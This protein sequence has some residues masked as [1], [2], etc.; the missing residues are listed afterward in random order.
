MGVF[1][2]AV[3]SLNLSLLASLGLVATE[4]LIIADLLSLALFSSDKLFELTK[5]SILN[6]KYNFNH[7]RRQN[8][9]L[10]VLSSEL[11]KV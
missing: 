1:W 2:P 4:D 10:S 8:I 5:S 7:Y 3:F 9:K 6:L 11:R